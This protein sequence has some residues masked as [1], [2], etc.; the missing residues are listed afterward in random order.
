MNV[1]KRNACRSLL[2]MTEGK[3]LLGRAIHVCLD[4]IKIDLWEIKWGGMG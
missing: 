2:G 3:R 4:N 1:E